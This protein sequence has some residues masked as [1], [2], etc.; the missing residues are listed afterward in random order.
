M[1]EAFAD[2]IFQVIASS[3]T[4]ADMTVMTTG[5]LT[6]FYPLWTSKGIVV[7]NH[8]VSSTAHGQNIGS[9]KQLGW[10]VHTTMLFLKAQCG[11]LCPTLWH[12]VGH[13]DQRTLVIEW[14]CRF[15]MKSLLKH[16][17]VIWRLSDRCANT[18]CPYNRVNNKY[19]CCLP[20]A[21][22]PHNSVSIERQ[23]LRIEQH[24]PV[25]DFFCSTS[26]GY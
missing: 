19:V 25:R 24:I 17:K 9:I 7:T 4:T 1:S 5:G 6:A 21:P 10:E 16:S 3:H 22:M 20:P 13:T 14:D 2:G 8:S 11:M 26:H 15:S 18:E 12:N 23:T